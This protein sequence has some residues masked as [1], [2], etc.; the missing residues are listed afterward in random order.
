MIPLNYF[1]DF[2]LLKNQLPTTQN[3]VSHII[4]V[5]KSRDIFIKIL[6]SMLYLSFC[7]TEEETTMP[8]L[9]MHDT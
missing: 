9:E 3:S 7:N 2:L 4:F 5:K 6:F 1:M 8:Q